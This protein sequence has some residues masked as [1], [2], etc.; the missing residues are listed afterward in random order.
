[1]RAALHASLHLKMVPAAV[2]LQTYLQAVHLRCEDVGP[3]VRAFRENV[4]SLRPASPGARAN[5]DRRRNV[6]GRN[7]AHSPCD[8]PVLQVSAHLHW[9]ETNQNLPAHLVKLFECGKRAQ[10]ENGSA[11]F[12]W[13]PFLSHRLHG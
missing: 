6:C 10:P 11:V 5:S 1:M 13:L 7:Q 3:A 4:R 12:S 2:A 8:E 9:R